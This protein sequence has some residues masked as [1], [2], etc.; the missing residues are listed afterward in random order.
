MLT[1]KGQHSFF[2]LHLE[3][4][5]PKPI[6]GLLREEQTGLPALMKCLTLIERFY[7]SEGDIGSLPAN[8]EGRECC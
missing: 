7:E 3:T 1:S 2:P 8:R 6:L 5:A 4:A